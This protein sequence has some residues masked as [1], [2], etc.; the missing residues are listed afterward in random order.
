MAS[1]QL[2]VAVRYIRRM[3]AGQL[4]N[5]SSD[6]QL[7]EDYTARGD[8][9]AFAAIAKRHGPMVLS[10]CRRVLG[11]EQDA[12]DAFQVTFLALARHAAQV[13]KKEALASWLHGVAYRTAMSAK[14]AAAR[15]RRHEGR[16][17]SMRQTTPCE[18]LTLREIQAML[19]EEVQRLPERYRI[20]FVLCYL[21]GKSQ[22]EVARALGL[23]QG[24]LWSR[25][26]RGRQQ[27]QEH[28]AKRGIAVPA[29]ILV[30]GAVSQCAGAAVPVRLLD[31]TVKAALQY[32]A[33]QAVA[34]GLLTSG[35]TT[36]LQGVTNA[37]F[38]SKC[39][40]ATA[41]LLAVGVIAGAGLLTRQ[42]L[43]GKNEDPAQQV[44]PQ[45]PAQDNAK[46][47]PAQAPG[48]PRSEAAKPEATDK[49]EVRGRVLDPDGK[50]LA[51]AKLH[52]SSLK[53]VIQ[54]ESMY[55]EIMYKHEER[56]TSGPDGLFRLTLTREEL[57]QEFVPLLFATAKGYGPDW[58]VLD[59]KN[60]D[61]ELSLRLVKDVPIK[62]RILNAEGRPVAGAKLRVQL[63]KFFGVNGLD[64]YLEYRRAHGYDRAASQ[65]DSVWGP[66]PG[67][68]T[69]ITSDTAGRFTLTGVGRERLVAFYITSGASIQ[70]GRPFEVMTRT[71]DTVRG[72]TVPGQPQGSIYGNVY[73]ANFDF[74]AAP[75]VPI[76]G[77]VR[78]K[79]TGK[80]VA[81]VTIS[82]NPNTT[83]T[84][85]TDKDG[86]YELLGYPRSET[87][88]LFAQPSEGQPYF[89]AK[90][91][92]P[93]TPGSDSITADIEL[94]SGILLS[95]R[96]ADAASKKPVKGAKVYYHPLLG[97]PFAAR[98]SYD[99]DRDIYVGASSTTTRAD[100]SFSLPVLPGPGVVALAC[101]GNHPYMSALLTPGEV[102]D[103]FKDDKEFHVSDK[104]GIIYIITS[105]EFY[106]A[107][108]L[109]NPKEK[110]ESVKQAL[111][112]QPGRT[113]TGTVLGTD[114]KPLAGATMEDLTPGHM[115]LV[116]LRTSSF[117]LTNVNP[118]RTR[119]L[120]FH[121]K[122]KGLGLYKVI[123][124]DSAEPLTVKLQPYG[125]V[126][127]R[128]LDKDGKPVPDVP[129]RID[130]D[131]G[132]TDTRVKTD[133]DGRFRVDSLVAGHTYELLSP[134]R[135]AILTLEDG[136]VISFPQFKIEPGKVKDFGDAKPSKIR[137]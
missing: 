83:S 113:L 4:H 119:G 36:L 73:G 86:G 89:A 13:R 128:I 101:P 90:I 108:A 105:I 21:E 29:A 135:A 76:R 64:K 131:G 99:R 42:V 75:S 48:S 65:G 74:V 61:G 92:Q 63:V 46:A 68:P 93:D 35:A 56:A 41:L 60:L 62:G 1:A 71:A 81:G 126:I 37:M 8:Q 70:H 98:I 133:R 137:E 3:A 100:G 96:V 31:T 47:Q 51:G 17:E 19:D 27:L 120:E 34:A 84:A 121:H 14:R 24:T 123:R 30:A 33:G 50:P 115:S 66:L 82:G 7:L 106:Q 67:Q 87:Y 85:R 20:P 130:R 80:P 95:G 52:L 18:E 38:V 57:A 114:G 25:L 94:I 125:S 107:L 118:Q 28:L 103:F 134:V 59:K 69:E 129:M 122:E 54:E 49:V 55:E 112:V 22:E 78:D 23:K 58:K 15:R 79:A 111:T 102:R 53:R 97:N 43:A 2:D 11:H 72:V 110:A 109:I 136:R 5:E 16:V 39:K 132:E 116:S 124:C 26:N 9:A 40:I 91:D 104:D 88:N 77:T 117:T 12:E 6:S 127:G 45:P 32:A 10:V 44:V